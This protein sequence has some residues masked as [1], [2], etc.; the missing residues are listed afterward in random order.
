MNKE[1]LQKTLQNKA[2]QLE[3]ISTLWFNE[4]VTHA[5]FNNKTKQRITLK[6][7]TKQTHTM[8]KET[9]YKI[10]QNLGKPI[11]EKAS[12]VAGLAFAIKF[13]SEIP[14]GVEKA[15]DIVQE[16]MLNYMLQS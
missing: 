3:K 16:D 5:I 4:I 7:N 15:R 1:Q 8:D 10:I 2:N 6:T 12:T 13:A 14:K 9:A 11:D